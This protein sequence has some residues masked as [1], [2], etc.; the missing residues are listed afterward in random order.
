MMIQV[1]ACESAPI[2]TRI[3]LKDFWAAE[4]SWSS[5]AWSKT[6]SKTGT[7]QVPNSRHALIAVTG[8]RRDQAVQGFSEK[9]PDRLRGIARKTIHLGILDRSRTLRSHVSPIRSGFPPH[10]IS[11]VGRVPHQAPTEL[12]VEDHELPNQANT[13]QK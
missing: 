9:R 8:K 1:V 5:L 3:G 6:R 4:A 11:H 13:K 12:R 7:K 10:P 2:F